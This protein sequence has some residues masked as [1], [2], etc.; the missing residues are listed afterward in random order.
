GG[1]MERS[2]RHNSVL[3][4]YIVENFLWSDTK[5]SE[6]GVTELDEDFLRPLADDVDLVHVGDPQQAL[7][8]VLSAVLECGQA[9]A[10]GR[11]HV[12][13]RI[14][15]AEFIV[16]IRTGDAGGQPLSSFPPPFPY[17]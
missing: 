7:A 11:Q 12:E 17:P 13:S 1:G 15:I 2:A 9:Q 3:P 4:R 10:V 14:D 8:H 6:F 5:P 16:E